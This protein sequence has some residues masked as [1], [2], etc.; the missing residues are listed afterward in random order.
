VESA[1]ALVASTGGARPLR[2]AIVDD[3]QMVLAGLRAWLD[4]A[5]G[6]LDV[7][8]SVESWT[9]LLTHPAFPVDVVLLDLDLGDGISPSLKIATLRSIGVE[10]I[11]VSNFAEPS[12]VQYC[13]TAGA[14][15]YLLKAEPP[16]QMVTAIKAAARK[17][18]CTSPTIAGL[19]VPDPST[20]AE[21]TTKPH[22][23]GQELRALAFYASGLP[24]KSV[25][26]RLGV[27]FD[28]AKGYVDRVRQKYATAG[29]EARTK[30]ELHHRAVED[31]IIPTQ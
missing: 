3:Q 31:G 5:N 30:L 17:D 24:M 20:A 27:N 6:N 19:L 28:T 7:V 23:S 11:I 1:P 14:R 22:L 18:G 12:Q 4:Q 8:C 10:T 16:E 21:P 13:L 29:R 26:I 9:G 25:A 2:V 15:S